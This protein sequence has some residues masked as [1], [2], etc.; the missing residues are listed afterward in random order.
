[1]RNEHHPR[2]GLQLVKLSLLPHH[3]RNSFDS[4]TTTDCLSIWISASSP[5]PSALMTLFLCQLGSSEM[6]VLYLSLTMPSSVFSFGFI[7]YCHVCGAEGVLE[8]WTTSWYGYQS[9]FLKLDRWTVYTSIVVRILTAHMAR[10]AQLVVLNATLARLNC[11]SICRTL[12]KHQAYKRP[13]RL[14]I[15][16]I[17]S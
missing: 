3:R 16:W 14:N 12:L 8:A 5:T 7:W 10:P 1:M 2:P 4:F 6:L 17:F 11:F 15:N 13:S 9:V